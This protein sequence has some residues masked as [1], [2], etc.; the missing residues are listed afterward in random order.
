MNVD[1]HG[2]I[3]FKPFHTLSDMFH[4][5]ARDFNLLWSLSKCLSTMPGPDGFP[6]CPV[7]DN[8][9]SDTEMIASK[10]CNCCVI[11]IAKLENQTSTFHDQVPKYCKNLRMTPL[12][13]LKFL[14]IPSTEAHSC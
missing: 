13:L 4:L 9:W 6:C 11:V 7:A 5:F 2:H 14:W 3:F 1:G 10:F 12:A 8:E